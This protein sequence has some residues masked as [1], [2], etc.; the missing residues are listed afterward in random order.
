MMVIMCNVGESDVAQAHLSKWISY[1]D[2]DDEDEVK[3]GKVYL[4]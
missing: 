3:D 4:P 1:N 2:D